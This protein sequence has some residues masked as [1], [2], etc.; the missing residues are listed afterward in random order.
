V[1]GAGEPGDSPGGAGVLAYLRSASRSGHANDVRLVA[2]NFTDAVV[3]IP[4]PPGEWTVEVSTHRP[5]SP[6]PL[7]G[8]LALAADEA[9][10]LRPL[11]AMP[12]RSTTGTP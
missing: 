6:G 3:E 8:R 2:V 7:N 11:R 12:G 9:T 1:G 10:I 5:M 4:T